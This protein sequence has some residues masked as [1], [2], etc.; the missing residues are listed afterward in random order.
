MAADP[1]SESADVESDPSRKSEE[2][3]NRLKSCSEL[4]RLTDDA[5]Y[6]LAV[7]VGQAE[8]PPLVAEG[9]ALVVDA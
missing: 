6:Q 4:G 2:C 8:P 1:M 9:Q 3:E 7:H 5:L